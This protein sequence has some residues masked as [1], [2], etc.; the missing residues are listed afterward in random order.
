MP[1]VRSQFKAQAQNVLSLDPMSPV[2]LICREWVG[3]FDLC[4]LDDQSIGFDG[5]ERKIT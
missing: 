2:Q 5:K 4:E 3:N 1:Y